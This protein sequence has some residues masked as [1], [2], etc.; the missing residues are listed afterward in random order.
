MALIGCW[1]CAKSVKDTDTECAHCG[2][3]LGPARL[4]EQEEVLSS[5]IVTTTANVEGKRITAYKGIV[6]GEAIVGVNVFLDLFAGYERVLGQARRTALSAL[7]QRALASGANAVVGVD[8]DYEVIG[9]ANGM[10]MVSASGT[11]V[12]VE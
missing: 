9:E 6:A 2:A 5:V 7:T 11:A 12:V 3:P 8:L 10:M 4:A 1:K